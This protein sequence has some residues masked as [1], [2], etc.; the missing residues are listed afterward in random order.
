VTPQGSLLGWLPVLGGALSPGSAWPGQYQFE[1]A[2]AYYAD[3][4]GLNR[5]LEYRY[6]DG[7]LYGVDP[8][9]GSISQVAALLT[10]QDWAVGRPMPA[11]YDVYNLPYGYRDRYVDTPRSLYRYDDGHVYQVD[12]TTQLVQA[13]IQLLT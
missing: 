9:T 3:Y 2:P 12:P 5:D 7:A 13:V 10:G 8:R 1:P 4:Y 6:A 11:G